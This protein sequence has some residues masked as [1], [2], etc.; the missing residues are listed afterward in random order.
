MKR[1]SFEEVEEA[2]II[3]G[4]E[5]EA[6]LGEIKEAYRRLTRRY[7][8]DLCRERREV[9]EEQIRKLNW[10]YEVLMSYVEGYRYSFRREDVRRNDPYRA[11]RRF[12]DEDWL[13]S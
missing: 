1:I 4:L 8:P 7:H 10:A 9:C 2:R 6:T 5:E 13:G 12:Y 3:L 11:V